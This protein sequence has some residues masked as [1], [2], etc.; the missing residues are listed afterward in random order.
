MTKISVSFGP[1]AGGEPAGA[2]GEIRRD[3]QLAA[4]ADLHPGDA[5]V[6]ARDHLTGAEL[7]AE[8]FAAAPGR[9][10]CFAALVA[11]AD[12]L[13]GDFVAG[14]GFGAVPPSISLISSFFGGGASA[15]STFG[16]VFFAAGFAFFGAAPS[17]R[18]SRS[19]RS[20]RSRC[21]RRNRLQ[22]RNSAAPIDDDRESLPRIGGILAAM[23]WRAGAH[24]LPES[25]SQARPR[26][27]R[28]PPPTRSAGLTDSA[29]GVAPRLR[30][31]LGL[32]RVD[33]Q[34]HAALVDLADLGRIDEAVATGP[35]GGV[36]DDP[37][38]D[39]EVRRREHL[40]RPRRAPP[41]RSEKTGTPLP[42]AR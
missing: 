3:D 15:R 23:Q 11:D 38:E 22:Q 5:L 20:T 40:R 35:G 36:E 32:A 39:V 28:V 6:P 25:R 4:A 21:R 10:E 34:H 26:K 24:P 29:A 16:L 33:L 42:S 7:E 8:G 13:D 1:I 19:F 41:R 30:Q 2:V 27:P 17:F 12:V 9:V 14:L 18:R 31:C 37:V